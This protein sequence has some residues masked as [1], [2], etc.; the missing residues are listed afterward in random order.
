MNPATVSAFMSGGSGFMGGGTSPVSSSATAIAKAGIGE[1]N[2]ST[3]SS[4]NLLIVG[5]FV[6]AGLV[7]WQ[8]Y[9]GK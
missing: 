9:K 1:M 4:K 6:L 8:L 7:L 2:F 3:P 5:S